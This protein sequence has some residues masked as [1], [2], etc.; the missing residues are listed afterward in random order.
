MTT[1]QPTISS[2]VIRGDLKLPVRTWTLSE[3]VYVKPRYQR[4]DATKKN[5]PTGLKTD[6][7]TFMG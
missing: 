7:S 6:A 4:E 2:R 5:T 1:T 3:G